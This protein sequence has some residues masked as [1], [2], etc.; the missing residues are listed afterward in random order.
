MKKLA[1]SAVFLG[2]LA[3]GSVQAQDGSATPRGVIYA[4]RGAMPAS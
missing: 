3:S 2:L 4:E 1:L